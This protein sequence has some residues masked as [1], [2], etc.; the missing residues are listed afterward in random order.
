MSLN[1]IISKPEIILLCERKLPSLFCEQYLG[2]I[3]R[4]E[5][6]QFKI[7][8]LRF[9]RQYY[10]PTTIIRDVLNDKTLCGLIPRSCYIDTDKLNIFRTETSRYII[11]RK[12][13]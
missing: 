12:K 6:F 9:D 5:N 11:I 8:G 2:E 7:N 3:L 13:T 10:R 4:A 1:K